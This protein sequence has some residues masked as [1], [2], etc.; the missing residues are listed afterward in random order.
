VR[1]DAYREALAAGRARVETLHRRVRRGRH[2]RRRGGGGGSSGLGGTY[3]G[4]RN[5][6]ARGF[7]SNFICGLGF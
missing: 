1:G 2:G 6:W 5:I 7:K 3:E 4:R